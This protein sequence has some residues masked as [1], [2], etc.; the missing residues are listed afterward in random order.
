VEEERSN[1][2]LGMSTLG[3]LMVALSRALSSTWNKKRAPIQIHPRHLNNL[4]VRLGEERELLSTP[5][6]S[7][8]HKISSSD[9]E[10]RAGSRKKCMDLLSYLSLI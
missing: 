2:M 4:E 8:L 9:S 6:Y 10:N 1:T 7:L 5:A 3:L